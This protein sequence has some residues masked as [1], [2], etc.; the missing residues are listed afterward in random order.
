MAFLKFARAAVTKPS[1]TVADWEAGVRAKAL[2]GGMQKSASKVIQQFD[3][4]QYLL[5]HCTIVASVDTEESS[6]PVGRQLVDGFQIDRRYADYL[7]TP[8][9]SQYINNN[10]DC[11]ERKLLLACFRT[12]IGAEN[13]VEHLQIPELSKGKIVD[14]AARDIGE[15]V[16]VD[17]LVATD[18]KH[19][20]LVT[21]VQS[22]QLQTLSMGCQVSFTV[23]TKCG[24]LAEDET[25]LCPHIRHMKGNTFLDGTG[26]S[27]KI[28]ELCGHVQAEPGSVKFIE[29]SWV[30]NPA[31]T[32][33][34]LRNILSPEEAASLNLGNRVQ[35][36]F[37][38]TP[39][40]ATPGMMNRA[41]KSL[42]N[43]TKRGEFDFGDEGDG[44]G[45]GEAPAAKDADP[46]DK[47]VSD[48]AEYIR[49]RAI[50]KIREE[51]SGETPPRADLDENL[52]ETMV[53]EALRRSPHWRKLAKVVMSRTKNPT[54]ARHMV[55]GLLLYRRGGWKAV[56]ASA[57][58]RGTDILALSRF[59][60]LFNQ[61][62]KIAGEAR[63]YRTVLAV[64]G[65][66]AYANEESYLSAC[67]RI[68]G[69][70]ITGTEKDALMTK[71]RL[72]DLGR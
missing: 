38:Q 35:V 39:R 51:M 15:S 20:P 72:Y 17:I 54:F 56:Q 8:E 30:A 19:G 46:M 69:R 58:F 45:G 49:E 23:C 24:N 70:E 3:P 59:L 48:M 53:K 57:A 5:S 16:Y 26:K 62:P 21:A 42:W 63:I 67:R 66:S 14:A 18:R 13:Y 33:A 29:A 41:A 36:A 1:I 71:G 2:S 9:S 65:V 50:K 64:G 32:G 27:R 47:A 44:G 28:A 60:D 7:V 43:S 12:F 34:V 22:G 40:M 68:I 52:N 25:Q 11:W 61:T 4:G 37:S 6:E 31:F 10:H 55:L